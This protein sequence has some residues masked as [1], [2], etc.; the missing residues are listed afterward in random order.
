[1]ARATRTAVGLA[2]ALMV[3]ATLIPASAA[4]TTPMRVGRPPVVPAG[5]IVR[6]TVAP[7]VRLHVA[8]A[9]KP[10]DPAALKAYAQAVSTPG[11]S[12]YHRYLNPAQFARR[13][14]ATPAAVHAVQRSLRARGLHPGRVSA[15]SL[16]IPVV[17][18]AGQLERGLKISLRRLALPGRRT[19]VAATA[20]PAL[21]ASTAHLVQ[22]VVGLDTVSAPH[23]LLVR[24]PP[25]WRATARARAALARA[26]VATGGPQPCAAAQSAAALQ[27]AHTIDQIAS[28]YGFSGLYAAGDRGAGTTVAIYELEP[29]DPSDIAAYQACY[30]TH[31]S[32]SYVSVDGGAGDGPGT[33]EAALDI[34]N[35]L[36]LVPR[37]RVLVYQG[38]NSSSGAPGS[39]PYDTFRAIIDQDRAQVVS[40]SWGECEAALGAPDAAAENT[41]FQQAAVQGQTII[42]AAGDSGSED[43][44]AGSDGQ[45][46]QLAVDDPASQPFITAVGGT[47]LSML[48]PESVWNSGAGP[49]TGLV[50][51]GATG[52]GISD[53]WPMPAAQRDASLALDV[54]GAGVS[55]PQCGHPGGYCREVPDVSADADPRT[56]YV[57]YFNGRGS[58]IGLPGGWQPIGGTSAAAPVW[59][60][61]MALADSSSPCSHGPIGYALPALYRAAG[62]SYATGFNDVRT[63]DN[64]F[65]HTNGGRFA[66]GVGY[67]EA[68]GL[69][70]PNAAALVDSLCA[71]ALRITAPPSQ[72][73][74]VSA[75]VSMTLRAHDVSGAAVRFH[76]TGLPPGL[77][78]DPAS[79]RITGRAKRTGSYRVT[80]VAQDVQGSRASARFSWVVGGAARLTDL[81][82]GQIGDHR[83]ALTFTVAT[84]HGAPALRGLVVRVPRQLRLVSP[85]GIQVTA[86]GGARFNA[87]VSGGS[88]LIE[89]QRAFRRLQVTIS[90]PAL[91]S[92][93]GRGANARGS[94]PPQLA[95]TV[96]FAGH[97][98]SHLHA[99]IQI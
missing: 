87:S 14:G 58:E 68:S 91:Q 20:A 19:A 6:G 88:L 24:P 1:M 97:Q 66:A 55:G 85:H 92:S 96:L 32:I 28:A 27:G 48:G 7:T 18:S 99:R 54:L 39:G 16:S 52:G 80:A 44:A 33:G 86:R 94:Q 46:T 70:T 29:V 93:G 4:Q 15:G 12:V 78:L 11:S 57:I 63:G 49:V 50:Q 31:S 84:G 43:C 34:E 73:S 25:G 38:R 47:T 13:F 67:D 10:R 41:L 83:P 42:S 74:A 26:H 69:G 30:G 89:L 76:A 56:G 64:D 5:A 71:E 90:Y 61:L 53:L 82:L 98:A 75:S 95:V 81:I 22:S 59:A 60:A 77:S 36:G 17:A 8:V 65:T 79:G 35:L 51:P 21:G 37:A 62:A 72:R 3:A 23:P 45:Q 2:C 40:V 9:L